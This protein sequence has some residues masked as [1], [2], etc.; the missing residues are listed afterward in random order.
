MFLE[1]NQTRRRISLRTMPHFPRGLFSRF[2][3]AA[4]DSVHRVG[5]RSGNLADLAV[6]QPDFLSVGDGI[7]HRFDEVVQVRLACV[8]DCAINLQASIPLI[9]SLWSWKKEV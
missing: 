3:H 1:V 4:T 9:V 8:P 7:G 5:F 6:I 2:E